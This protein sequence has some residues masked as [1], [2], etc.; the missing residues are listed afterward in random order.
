MVT[1]RFFERSAKKA[2]EVMPAGFAGEAEE[3]EERPTEAATQR[4]NGTGKAKERIVEG[5]TADLTSVALARKAAQSREFPLVVCTLGGFETAQ[6][7]AHIFSNELPP[8]S[9]V[10]GEVLRAYAEQIDAMLAGLARDFPD[11]TLVVVSPS[12]PVPPPLPVENHPGERHR[13]PGQTD[14]YQD[15]DPGL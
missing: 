4:F 7:A 10:K 2:T 14:R 9:T 8:R 3:L 15:D 5:L 12:G 6:R 11:H 1:D 13:A